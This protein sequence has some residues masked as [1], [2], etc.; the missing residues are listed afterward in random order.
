[1]EGF[2]VRFVVIR[3]HRRQASDYSSKFGVNRQM[4]NPKPSIAQSAV[5]S[6]VKFVR[7]AEPFAPCLRAGDPPKPRSTFAE[8]VV[9]ELALQS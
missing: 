4:M 5:Q 8:G 7:F 3:L 6:A 2:F 9:L 1:L